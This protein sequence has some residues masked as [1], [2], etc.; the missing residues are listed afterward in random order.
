[1]IEV[2]VLEKYLFFWGYQPKKNCSIA[3]N[4]FSQWF[5]AG[6]TANDDYYPTAEH[7]MMAEKARCCTMQN[8]KLITQ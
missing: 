2:E 8:H 6:F 7:Y 5:E 1:L 4:C 3:K